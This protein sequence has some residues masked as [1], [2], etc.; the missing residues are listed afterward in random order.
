[1]QWARFPS[2]PEWTHTCVSYL[3]DGIE[4]HDVSLLAQMAAVEGDTEEGGKREEFQATAAHLLPKDPVVRRK[5]TGV[6]HRAAKISEVNANDFE[7]EPKM[8]I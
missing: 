1:M 8:G 5:T 3:L 2:A 4:T 6:K 7:V